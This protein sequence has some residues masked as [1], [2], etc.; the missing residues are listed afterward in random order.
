MQCVNLSDEDMVID[1]ESTTV[2]DDS[3]EGDRDIEVIA[4]YRETPVYAPSISSGTSDDK[5]EEQVQSLCGLSGSVDSTFDPTDSFVDWFI[6]SP[7]L[8]T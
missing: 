8:G 5:G 4:C 6:G 2:I 1:T 3:Q 7:T